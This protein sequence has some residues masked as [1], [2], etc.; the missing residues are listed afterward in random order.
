MSQTALKNN[1][2]IKALV[3]LG[4][5]EREAAFLYLVARHSGFF[6]RR[7]YCQFIEREAGGTAAALIEKLTSKGHGTVVV[8]CG[9]SNIY[10]LC[11]RT[12]YGALGE[13]DNRNRR[14]RPPIAI[15]NKL[16][17]LDFV[18]NHLQCHFLAT[19]KE[20]VSYFEGLGIERCDLPAKLFRSPN[21]RDETLRYFVDKYPIFLPTESPPAAP[22]VS[23][24]FIDEGVITTGRFE[25]YLKQYGRLFARLPRFNLIYVA[26]WETEFAMAE[27]SFRN[28]VTSD[29][30]RR[31]GRLNDTDRERLLCH[32]QDRQ[33]YESG[34]ISSLDRTRLIRLR[35]EREVFSGRRFHELY[36]CW[37][38][39]GEA[40]VRAALAKQAPVVDAS[41]ANFSTYLL[42]HNYEIFGSFGASQP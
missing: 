21:G 35:D 37:K 33:L 31:A 11:S 30:Q 41:R 26:T 19:E 12:F 9:N 29:A 5:T 23:F 34:Q 8:G 1:E 42:R 18:L 10:H 3:R 7:Q 32:F 14:A 16:M 6:V 17:G 39:T 22:V 28:L 40:G 13:E 27:K 38:T 25:T 24:C 15:K 36:G 20:K 2:R 4:Y